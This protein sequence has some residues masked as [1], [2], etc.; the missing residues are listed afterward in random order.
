EGCI[1]STRLALSLAERTGA[2]L[3]VLHVTTSEEIDLFAPY[4]DKD[5]ISCEV[6]P[7]HWLFSDRDYA[8]WGN[9]LKVNPAIK[10]AEDSAALWAAIQAGTVSLIGSDHAP[11]TQAEKNEPYSGS[12]SGMPM[13]QH[14]MYV[15]LE[16]A[17]RGEITL[18]DV[19]RLC[20]HAPALRCGIRERGVLAEGYFADIAVFTRVAP[21]TVPVQYACG[22]SVLE[23]RLFSTRCTY[24]WVNGRLVWEKGKHIA[25][26]YG[27]RLAFC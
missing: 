22:W 2:R 10:T 12:P 1:A 17:L 27:Q 3:H 13:V 25:G 9:F 4:A 26:I 23:D 8:K 24:T 7:Q 5:Q 11:H 15:L 6:C 19:V 18:P 20:S 16:A 14:R 21:A